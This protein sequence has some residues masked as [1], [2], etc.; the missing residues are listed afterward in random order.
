MCT[1]VIFIAYEIIC[2]LFKNRFLAK[3]KDKNERTKSIGEREEVENAN[4]KEKK[5]SRIGIIL[6][7]DECSVT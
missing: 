6:P 3:I 7:I 2:D 5:A 1:C 4:A